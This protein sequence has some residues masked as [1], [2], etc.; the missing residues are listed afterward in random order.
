MKQNTSDLAASDISVVKYALSIFGSSLLGT[1]FCLLAQIFISFLYGEGLW[2]AIVL[3]L[4]CLILYGPIIYMN[5]WSM[6]ARDRNASLYGH[7]KADPLRGGKAGL[8]AIVPY[9][10]CAFLLALAKAGV[11]PDFLVLFRFI[12]SPFAVFLRY[13]LPDY[14]S[15]V[16]YWGIFFS[17]ITQLFCP[18]FAQ[19]G[20]VLGYRDISLYHRLIYQNKDTKK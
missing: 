18:V 3:Q 12:Y 1:G 17:A 9:L 15:D 19:V 4:F 20:Y 8:L 6:G 2:G 16:T 5:A 14:L 11:F 13:L 10:A 7:I